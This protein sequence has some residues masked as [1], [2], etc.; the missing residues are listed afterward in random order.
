MAMFR[1]FVL[2]PPGKVVSEKE[3]QAM[4]RQMEGYRDSPMQG[5]GVLDEIDK[6]KGENND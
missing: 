3:Y 2:L 1:R 5:R 6:Y 4:Q